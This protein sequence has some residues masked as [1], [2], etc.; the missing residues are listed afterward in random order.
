MKF[1]KSWGRK[2]ATYMTF[3]WEVLKYYNFVCMYI[4]IHT[5]TQPRFIAE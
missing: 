4:N 2:M 1:R 3:A 5:D